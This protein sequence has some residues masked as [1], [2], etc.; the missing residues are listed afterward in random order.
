MMT[1][2]GVEAVVGLLNLWIFF[3][4]ILDLFEFSF[5]VWVFS[6][7]SSTVTLVDKDRIEHKI[8]HWLARVSKTT[9]LSYNLNK[10]KNENKSKWPIL[11]TINQLQ[12]SN[13]RSV[14][15][16]LVHNPWQEIHTINIPWC[17]SSSQEKQQKWNV[18][19]SN[20][21]IIK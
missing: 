12:I 5:L 21:F 19:N 7:S 18:K 9:S 20:V 10:I 16:S 13:I 2:K 11:F 17:S 6:L 15:M 1:V 3:M 14:H 4:K 8:G